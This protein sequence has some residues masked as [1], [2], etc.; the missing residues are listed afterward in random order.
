MMQ[1]PKFVR[2]VEVGPRDGLQNEKSM[3]PTAVKV[4]LVNRLSDA[5]LTV[6]EAASFVSPKWVPQMGD[7]A[8]VLAGIAR[9]PGVRYAAL[10]PN[11]KGLEGALAAKADE[12]AV[13]GAAS[14][15]FSRKNINCSIAESLD[16]FAP[17][18]EQAKAAGVP[19]RGYVSCVLGCPYE[20]EIAPQ[21]VADVAERLYA[22]GC[23]EIS[24][25]D[26]IGTGTPTKAQLMIAAVAERVP[27]DKIAV[28]FHDTYG[29]ALANIL[30]ALQMGV[31]VVDSSVAGLG[32]CPYAKGASGNVASE[33]V[34]YMLNGLGIETGVDL[35]RLVAAGAFISEAIGRPT[36][37]KVARARGCA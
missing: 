3:V 25:G 32:G 36:A 20:G 7:S 17:V 12:V 24:L 28:H 15:S 4:E 21:A 23:Y 26:T 22:M 18:M 5:G 6:V 13:F 27:V 10:T 16:R 34:L 37:S 30:A 8:E 14:E 11:L 33:D 31:A 2:M 29:Q 9:K 19:V 1:L 35:D